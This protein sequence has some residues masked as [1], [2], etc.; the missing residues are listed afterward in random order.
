MDLL[1]QLKELLKEAEVPNT[2]VE[3]K[4]N[5]FLKVKGSVDT[6]IYHI[7]E[8]TLRVFIE[9][10]F[11][12][13]TI[14]LGYAGNFIAALDSFISD[15]PSELYIQA[16]KKCSVSAYKKSDYKAFLNSSAEATALWQSMNEWLI[17]QQLEREKDILTQS[18]K[19]RYER[20]LQRSPRLFQEIPMKYIAS[21][22]RMSPET[23]SRLRNS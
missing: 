4:R 3:L 21:Y 15:Q 2:T 22:L 13:H 20:V 18:P 16:L 7:N 6:H 23:L 14:R 9:D 1:S 17:Y 19:T 11:E 12:E 10:E 8:G 5:E